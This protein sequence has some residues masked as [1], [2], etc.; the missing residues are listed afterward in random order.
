MR[1]ALFITCFNDAL[2]PATGR[3]VVEVLERLG[4]E[5]VFPGCQTCCGQLHLNSGYRREALDLARRFVEC[6]EPYEAIVA[7]S[8][9]C[10]GTVVD[11]YSQ[12]A[13]D[14]GDSA[15]AR[16]AGSLPARVHELSELLVDVLGIDDVGACF[17]H[18]VAYHPTCH[19]LRLLRSGDRPLRLLR[20]VA[21]LELVEVQGAETCCGFGGLFALK[22]AATSGAML[23]DKLA[24]LATSGAEV[25]CSLDNSCLT[26]LHGG[27]SRHASTLRFVHLAEVLA[28]TSEHVAQ[29]RAGR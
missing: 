2:Y 12:L 20:N 10:V 8:A 28:S 15:L 24:A 26:H 5:V 4:H 7:P 18:R 14:L 27:A 29:G 19:S 1:V 9:S 11:A 16:A 13:D 23:E 21:G 17:P 6:F 3:A 25:V 22:N